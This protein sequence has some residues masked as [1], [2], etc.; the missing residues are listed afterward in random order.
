MIFATKA[1]RHEETQSRGI[2]HEGK[3]VQKIGF[4]HEATKTQRN[5]KWRN[6]PRR[7]IGAEDR[8][9]TTK[10]QRH[11]EARSL[12]FYSFEL[13]FIVGVEKTEEIR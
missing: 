7:K 8:I 6:L 13:R 10:A 4:C 1:Q 2:C 12:I 5:T 3:K 11:E 9:F